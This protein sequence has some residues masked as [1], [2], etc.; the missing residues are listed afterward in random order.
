MT[1]R[2]VKLSD[3][4]ENWEI[5]PRAAFSTQWVATLVQALEDGAGMPPPVVARGSLQIVDGWHRVRALRK[6]LGSGAEVDADVRVFKSQ[7]DMLRA[8]VELNGPASRNA[9]PLTAA[10]LQKAAERMEA[11]GFPVAEIA[12]MLAM[13]EE[14]VRVIL[15]PPVPQQPA[16]PEA[17]AWAAQAQETARRRQGDRPD[18]GGGGDGRGPA[19]WAHLGHVRNAVTAVRAVQKTVEAGGAE[20]RDAEYQAALGELLAA[21]ESL[22]AVVAGAPAA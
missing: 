18:P 22:S 8:A 16:S 11:E 15:V 9:L 21:M 5:Y 7:A 20:V 1:V 3:L 17:Q 4:R 6:Y 14:R 2:K 13:P 10:D 12:G 19:F